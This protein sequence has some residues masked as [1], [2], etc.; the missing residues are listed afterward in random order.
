MTK[1]NYY[2]IQVKVDS[3]FGEKYKTIRGSKGISRND[4]SNRFGND[5]SKRYNSV[6]EAE[7][8]IKYANKYT[9]SR[10]KEVYKIKKLG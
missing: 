5:L 1:Q 4:S 3:L 8:A 6:K 2:V 10:D 9:R 7:K